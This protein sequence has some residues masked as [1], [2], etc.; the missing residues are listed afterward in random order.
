V[1]VSTAEHSILPCCRSPSVPQWRLHIFLSGLL[2]NFV[3][4]L[5]EFIGTFGTQ[6]VACSFLAVNTAVAL[7]TSIDIEDNDG[8]NDILYFVNTKRR[9]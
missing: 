1:F 8:E 3:T 9:R 7:C 6:R 4:H 2:D 5:I